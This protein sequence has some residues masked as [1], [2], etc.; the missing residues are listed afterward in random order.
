MKWKI[1]FWAVLL[2]IGGAVIVVPIVLHAWEFL[3]A[4]G[5]AAAILGIGGF[6]SFLYYM[7]YEKGKR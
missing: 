3:F 4:I 6:I 1:L 7:A 5:V 2:L